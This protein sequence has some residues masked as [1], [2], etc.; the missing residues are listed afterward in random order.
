MHAI[1]DKENICKYILNVTDQIRTTLSV[2][3]ARINN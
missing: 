1:A 3:L 2:L